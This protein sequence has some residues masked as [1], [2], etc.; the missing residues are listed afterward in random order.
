M[1]FNNIKTEAQF[2]ADLMPQSFFDRSYDHFCKALKYHPFFADRF[3]AVGNPEA[4]LEL[5]RRQ[6]K[7][8]EE[9]K[10]LSACDVLNCEVAEAVLAQREGNV[11]HA[12]DEC[13][14]AIA[15]LMRMVSV[16]EGKQKLGREAHDGE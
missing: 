14:D 2:V 5:R 16:L 7:M 1:N 8:F 13:Y 9:R 12:I 15:V 4:D 10:W 3:S 6:L 11:P